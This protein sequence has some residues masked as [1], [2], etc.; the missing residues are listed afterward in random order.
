MHGPICNVRLHIESRRFDKPVP[1]HHENFDPVA[2][3][4]QHTA[5][6]A[7]CPRTSRRD[8]KIDRDPREAG[9]ECF[10]DQTI[11][12]LNDQAHQERTRGVWLYEIADLTGM[13]KADVDGVKAFA[14]RIHDR[15]RPAYGRFMVDQP[16]RCV[17]FATT[18]NDTYLKSQTGNRRFW[19]VKTARIN[20]VGLRRDRDQVWAEAAKIEA[21]EISLALPEHLWGL[22]RIEQE[23][24]QDHDPWDDILAS[25]R[26]EVRAAED[27]GEEERAATT[28][29]W[30]AI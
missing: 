26:G 18:N 1:R 6:I 10:S 7:R 23:K 16:R 17:F 28:K 21:M 9:A 13:S 15:A 22:A 3:A 29:L 4:T 2:M 8:A 5:A 27:G 12:G 24:R 20:I 19:P 30:R 25:V 14:S 11:L